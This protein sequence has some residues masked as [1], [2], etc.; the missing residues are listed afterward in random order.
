MEDQRKPKDLPYEMTP[1]ESL[2]R[3]QIYDVISTI[4]DP[5]KPYTLEDL[6]VVNDELIMV[7]STKDKEYTYAIIKWV[8]TVPHCH[9]ALTIALCMRAK[10]ERELGLPNL[11]IDIIVEDGKHQQKGEIDR[12]VNDKE[13]YSAALE[14]EE[15]MDVIEDLIKD[16]Y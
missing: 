11:K 3:D 6:D 13:R 12:Q 2:L 4:R 16:Q 1:E 8:P 5:E 7:R 10:I 14:K 15:V 9:L